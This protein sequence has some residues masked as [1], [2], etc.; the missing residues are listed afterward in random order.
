MANLYSRIVCNVIIRGPNNICRYGSDIK[1][2]TIH[3][4][5]YIK[6]DSS[7]TPCDKIGNLPKFKCVT[8]IL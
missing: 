6:K 3:G 1:M 2:V 8:I 4:T 5:D 7:P